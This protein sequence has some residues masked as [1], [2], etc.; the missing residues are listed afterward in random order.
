LKTEERL[1]DLNRNSK[2]WGNPS[3]ILGEEAKK[4][5]RKGQKLIYD[6]LEVGKL[7][8]PHP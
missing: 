4:R 7:A 3:N 5:A 6:V 2:K 1:K 8:V